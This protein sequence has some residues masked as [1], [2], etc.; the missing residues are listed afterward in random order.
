MPWYAK[1]KNRVT[2]WE[3][4][5]EWREERRRKKGRFVTENTQQVTGLQSLARHYSTSPADVQHYGGD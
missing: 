4:K 5:S 3:E 1:L 2:G